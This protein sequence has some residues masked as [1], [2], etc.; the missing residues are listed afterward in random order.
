MSLRNIVI[1][2]CKAG[3]T[4]L[5]MPSR[6][7]KKNVDAFRQ[8]RDNHRRNIAYIRDLFDGIR[9]QAKARQ[10]VDDTGDIES[11]QAMMDRRAANAPSVDMLTRHFLR[12]KRWA[13]AA[14]A[15]FTVLAIGAIA[16]GHMLGIATLLSALPLFFMASLSAQLRLWQLR[17]K[18]LS[19]SEKGGLQDF[20]KEIDGWYWEVLDPELGKS[21]GERR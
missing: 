18:R 9:T 13:L 19:P 3:A 5:R 2:A 15:L 16:S 12:Q 17:N 1:C 14:A 21:S 11:F 7:I 20:I 10:A 8:A 4:L 6:A